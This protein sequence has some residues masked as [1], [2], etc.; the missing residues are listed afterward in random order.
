QDT[1]R[2]DPPAR[3]DRAPAR[4]ERARH[5]L[6]WTLGLAA[7]AAVALAAAIAVPLS[8]GAPASAAAVA[9][10]AAAASRTRVGL[11]PFELHEAPP[12]V[13]AGFQPEPPP[14]RVS[15]HIEYA[16]RSHWRDESVITE[17]FRRGTQTITQIRNG[18][19]IAT[20]TGGRVTRSRAVG[21]GEV[22]FVAVRGAA[23]RKLAAAGSSDR[24]APSVSL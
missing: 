15:E 10:R 22:P 1:G 4:R 23:L 14:P 18:S 11:P 2:Q 17:P 24:C 19:R 8:W 20:V 16:D 3:P 9:R 13:P 6:R 12:T 5:R 7:A 21:W